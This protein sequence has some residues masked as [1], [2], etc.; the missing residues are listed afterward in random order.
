LNSAERK[1]EPADEI[2]Q[3]VPDGSEKRALHAVE[4]VLPLPAKGRS[5]ALIIEGNRWV[6]PDLRELWAHRELFLFLAW[7]DVKVRY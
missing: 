6:G 7:R 3:Y 2:S 5:P 1:L 4:D